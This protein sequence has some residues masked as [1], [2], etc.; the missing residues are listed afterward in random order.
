MCVLNFLAERCIFVE[1]HLSQTVHPMES[2]SNPGAAHHCIEPI[3]RFRGRRCSFHRK[4]STRVL[5]ILSDVH[6]FV[7]PYVKA[8]KIDKKA[9]VDVPIWF[10]I[11]SKWPKNPQISTLSKMFFI[12]FAFNWHVFSLDYKIPAVEALNGDSHSVQALNGVSHLF[13][14]FCGCSVR[15]NMKPTFSR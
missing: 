6:I 5:N 12:S 8:S 9:T 1:P 2:S 3:E 4:I 14:V 10:Y 15:C 7:E 13:F 11:K